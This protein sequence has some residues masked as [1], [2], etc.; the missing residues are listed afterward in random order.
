MLRS[1][2]RFF[3]DWILRGGNYNNVALHDKIH[4]FQVLPREIAEYTIKNT[5]LARLLLGLL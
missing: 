5:A 4:F 3:G 2:G 1:R